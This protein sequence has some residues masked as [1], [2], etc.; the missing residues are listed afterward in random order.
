[1]PNMSNMSFFKVFKS[2]FTIEMVASETSFKFIIPVD[3]FLTILPLTLPPT[4]ITISRQGGVLEFEIP[5]IPE[6][7]ERV[8]GQELK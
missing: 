5:R 1:M 6:V 4:H 7:P 3:R 2:Q 8:R